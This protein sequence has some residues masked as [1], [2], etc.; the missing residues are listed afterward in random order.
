MSIKY[1]I[2]GIFIKIMNNENRKP[3][4]DQIFIAIWEYLSKTSKKHNFIIYN[5]LFVI[6]L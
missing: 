2:L 5:M 3:P 1:N 4:G 6:S